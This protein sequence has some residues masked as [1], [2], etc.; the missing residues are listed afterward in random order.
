M[1]ILRQVSEYGHFSIF[2]CYT[3]SYLSNNIIIPAVNTDCIGITLQVYYEDSDIK[4]SPKEFIV[5]GAIDSDM[6]QAVYIFA[7]CLRQFHIYMPSYIH[8]HFPDYSIIKS[9]ISSSVGIFMCLYFLLKNIQLKYAY[10]VTGELDIYGNI[11][12]IGGMKE[13]KNVF[14]CSKILIILYC[15]LLIANF[16]IPKTIKNII[17]LFLYLP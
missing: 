7:T 4:D 13:K 11:H 16:L 1:S 3:M 6:E 2:S 12:E 9:G 10:L 5:T 17:N 8:I 14:L 15:L